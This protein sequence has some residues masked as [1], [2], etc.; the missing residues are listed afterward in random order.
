MVESARAQFREGAQVR[1]KASNN[2]YGNKQERASGQR[3]GIYT[4]EKS[5]MG[6]YVGKDKSGNLVHF[7]ADQ[8]TDVLDEH[9]L[10]DEFEEVNDI[11]DEI[12]D[13]QQWSEQITKFNKLEDIPAPKEESPKEEPKKKPPK[14]KRHEEEEDEFDWEA[15]ARELALEK[16]LKELDMGLFPEFGPEKLYKSAKV[17]LAKLKQIDQ[18]K[19]NK[20]IWEG[21]DPSRKMSKLNKKRLRAGIKEAYANERDPYLHQDIPSLA[22]ERIGYMVKLAQ[23]RRKRVDYTE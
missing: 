11:E 1:L 17:I 13:P 14:K 7:N 18:A 4:I 12:N 22:A 3:P 15:E 8:I 2:P 5:G 23:Q 10:D 9:G 16:E 21:K 20:L 6:H 19:Y